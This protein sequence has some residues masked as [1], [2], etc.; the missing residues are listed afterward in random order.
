MDLRS[1]RIQATLARL[2][3]DG[4]AISSRHESA[5]N[6]KGIRWDRVIGA[7]RQPRVNMAR[8]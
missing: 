1:Q 2:S 5:A 8:A 6:P 7:S 4:V 3:C